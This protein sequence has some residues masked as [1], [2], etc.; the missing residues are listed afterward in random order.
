[1][2][3]RVAARA[4]VLC[5]TPASVRAQ[6]AALTV[7][8]TSA[9]VHQ[10][11]S[12]GTPTSGHAQGGAVLAV[13]RELGSWV[14]V[15]WP[16]ARDGAGYLHVSTGSLTHAT[17]PAPAAAPAAARIEPAASVS[18]SSAAAR[19][20]AGEQLVPR[21]SYVTP[22]THIVGVGGLLGGSTFGYG[23]TG[24]VWSK[25]R[26]GFQLRFS[27]SSVTI[28]PSPDRLSSTQFAP[29]VLYSWPD[30]VTD[31][32]WVR[33]Y[34]GGGP[35]IHH[36]TVNVGLLGAGGTMSDTSLGF[37]SFGGGE[38]TF[39]NVPRFA[40]SAELGYRWTKAPFPGFDLGGVGVAVS[41]HWYVR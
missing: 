15:S 22:P 7:R 27:H 19:S 25:D 18:S 6:S 29:S 8:A 16:D 38:L 39:P 33:P 26:L 36:Q 35:N 3:R 5:L 23:V 41:A 31:S 14:K 11:A 40:V 2:L 9:D 37:Q 32:V 28:D 4:C 30:K 24:R 17:A 12:T 13:S 20:S 10:A 1:M 34:V 21:S